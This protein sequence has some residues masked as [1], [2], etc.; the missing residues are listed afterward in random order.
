M[1]RTDISLLRNS[2]DANPA[3]NRQSRSDQSAVCLLSRLNPQP[4]HP[5]VVACLRYATDYIFFSNRVASQPS[6][7][8]KRHLH[9]STRLARLAVSTS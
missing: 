3:R 8:L 2:V 6:A 4:F 7:N 5:S 9:F 1:D